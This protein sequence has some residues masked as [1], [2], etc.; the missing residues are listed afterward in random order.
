MWELITKETQLTQYTDNV[1]KM[2][3][4]NENRTIVDDHIFDYDAVYPFRL[5][6]GNIIPTDTTGFVYCLVSLRN[7]DQ[8]YVGET[9]CLSQ[10]LIKHNS[11]GGGSI[12]TQDIY[13]RPWTVAAYICGLSHMKRTERMSLVHRWKMSIQ[14]LQTRGYTDAF[15]WINSGADIVEMY[16]NGDSEDIIHYIRLI[17]PQ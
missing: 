16:N 9:T 1:L 13:N 12:S 5:N 7:H 17:S 3:T 11:G 10:R 8:I 2:I 4:M 14:S 6:D 15:T